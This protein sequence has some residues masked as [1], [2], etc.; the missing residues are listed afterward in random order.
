VHALTRRNWPEVATGQWDAAGRSATEAL[1]L[2][3]SS[4]QPVLAAWPHAV[5]ALLAAFRGEEAAVDEHAGA[6]ERVAAGVS[7]G[8][9]TEFVTDLVRWARGLRDAHTPTA[10]LPQLEQ[11]GTLIVRQLAAV[12]RI[13]AAVRAARPDLAQA[14]LEDIAAFAEGT[15]AFWAKAV[16]EHGRALLADGAATEDHFC[17]ALELHASSPRIPDR[18]RTELAFGSFLRRN[19]RRVEARQHLRAALE[20]FEALG[21]ELWA[22]RARQELR[23]SGETA[24]RRDT[25]DAPTLTPSERQIA[26]LVREGLSNREIAARLF[27]SPRTVDFHL[28]NVFAKVGVAS[29]G[30]LA[31]SPLFVNQS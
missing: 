22:E 7:L 31:A 1:A 2:A 9:V 29:R 3:E 15:G 14:W 6:V 18:A 16:V 28:R 30:E 24:R 25:G 4:G 8:I 5:L 21:A 27:V 11:I 10:G 20:R 17:R 23:A 12:D 13:D 19:R 26:A